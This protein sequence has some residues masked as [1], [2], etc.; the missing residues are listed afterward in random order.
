MTDVLDLEKMDDY[1]N[2]LE[3]VN[4]KKEC[5]ICMDLCCHD[6]LT[7]GNP[8]CDKKYCLRCY[9]KIKKS[10]KYSTYG[11]EQLCADFTCPFCRVNSDIGLFN[12]KDKNLIIENAKYDYITTLKEN[13]Y[14]KLY[15]KKLENNEKINDDLDVIIKSTKSID[16]KT[17]D[18]ISLL[19]EEKQ[20]KIKEFEELQNTFFELEKRYTEIRLINENIKLENENKNSLLQLQ[21]YIINT[22]ND[23][24]NNLFNKNKNSKTIKKSDLSDALKYHANI[25]IKLK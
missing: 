23:N 8:K 14:R 9:N 20:Q 3:I 21:H 11:E 1:L 25:T 18:Y 13:Y 4:S 17:K 6:E 5:D 7:C 12:Y 22:T 15:I 2:K 16:E 19:K 10:I 24:I